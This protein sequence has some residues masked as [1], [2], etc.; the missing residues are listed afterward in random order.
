[1]STSSLK[2]KSKKVASKP[3]KR[4]KPLWQELVAPSASEEDIDIAR[5]LPEAPRTPSKS[6]NPGILP[7]SSP[8]RPSD[9]IESDVFDYDHVARMNGVGANEDDE[10]ELWI[11]RVP[12]G[13]RPASLQFIRE[14]KYSSHARSSR[15]HLSPCKWMHLLSPFLRQ[16][17]RTH[18]LARLR[19][20]TPRTMFGI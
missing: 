12:Q 9:F 8:L 10:L 6:Q 19:A 14:F 2:S 20:R 15:K 5:E 11:I 3:E 4:N 18:G 1:M 13:V 16:R 17:R 7:N